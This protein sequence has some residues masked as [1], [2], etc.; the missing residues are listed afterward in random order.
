MNDRKENHP[1]WLRMVMEG[2]VIV[3]SILLAFAIDAW[4]DTRQERLVLN[5]HLAALAEDVEEARADAVT[6]QDRRERRIAII[7]NLLGVI[8]DGQPAP[9][10]DTLNAW[11]G[12]LWGARSPL[13]PFAALEDLR[14]SGVLTSIESQELRRALFNY[15]RTAEQVRELENRVVDVWQE[16]LQ[17]YLIANTD[18][19]PQ[20]KFR[21]NLDLAEYEPAF[22]S[23]VE[24]LF[25]DRTFQ[26][27][28]LARLNRTVSAYMD[29]AE[30]IA[31]LERIS[32]LLELEAR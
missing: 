25:A 14:A 13:Q 28:L 7:Y 12:A 17:P 1:R 26:N 22:S 18:V 2:V 15:S 4:W 31:L 10:S 30:V 23:G 20:A 16:G 8:A 6:S 9:S 21:N 29:S 24:T 3:A 32:T 27:L 19:L 11:L 5:A